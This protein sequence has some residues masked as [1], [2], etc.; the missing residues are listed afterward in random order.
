MQRWLKVT[1]DDNYS[2]QQKLSQ[3]I[4]ILEDTDSAAA[5]CITV[6]I[7]INEGRLNTRQLQDLKPPKL[8]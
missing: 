1:F 8:C 2:D 4:V 7:Y 6:S 5:L 3:L